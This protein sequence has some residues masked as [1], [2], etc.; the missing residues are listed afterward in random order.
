[1]RSQR[2]RGFTLVE[3]LVVMVIVAILAAIAVPSYRQYVVRSNRSAAQSQMM[4]IANR[5]QQFLLADR[6]YADKASLVASG[7]VLSPE[8]SKFYTWDVETPAGGM[9]SF[10]I[11]LTPTGAQTSDGALTL[12]SQGNKAPIDKWQR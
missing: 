1:M 2:T 9:P 3:I 10:Q 6:A 4:D 5:E 12:D 11:T 7:Y 8:V